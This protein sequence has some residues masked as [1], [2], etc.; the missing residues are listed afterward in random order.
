MTAKRLK[1]AVYY[2]NGCRKNAAHRPVRV[3]SNGGCADCQSSKVLD[4]SMW[5]RIVLPA[6]ISEEQRK[7]LNRLSID[8][9]IGR[10]LMDLLTMFPRGEK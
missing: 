2:G 8:G 7:Q 6:P 1:D 10:A 5:K 3:T 9:T 4:A